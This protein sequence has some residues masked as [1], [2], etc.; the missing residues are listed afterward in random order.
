M[1]PVAFQYARLRLHDLVHGQGA[2]IQLIGPRIR[3]HGEFRRRK[4]RERR[5]RLVT[6]RQHGG[7]GRKHQE[8]DH[9]GRQRLA[10][11]H[12]DMGH[13]L[14]ERRR[15]IHCLAELFRRRLA[16]ALNTELAPA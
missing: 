7:D 2:G 10:A 16:H 9:E 11:P 1:K 12:I 4:H 6:R 15:P 14:A 8:H 3:P 5:R 13:E